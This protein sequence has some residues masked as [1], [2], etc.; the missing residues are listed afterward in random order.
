[1]LYLQLPLCVDKD[2]SLYNEKEQSRDTV[3]EYF[4]SGA[5]PSLEQKSN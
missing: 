5:Q 3:T 4:F 1:M 2:Q